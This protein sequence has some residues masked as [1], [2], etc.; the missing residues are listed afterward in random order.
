VKKDRV[1]L[2][3]IV[4]SA[5]LRSKGLGKAIMQKLIKVAKQN[6]LNLETS[7]PK[8]NPKAFKFYQDNGFK[9]HEEKEKRFELFMDLNSKKTASG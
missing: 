1:R 5:N 7:V 8:L 2:A 4:L 9:I 6:S 3:D